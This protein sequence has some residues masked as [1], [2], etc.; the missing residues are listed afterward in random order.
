MQPTRL[1]EAAQA[2]AQPPLDEYFN[3]LFTALGPQHWWPGKTQ[4]EVIVGAILTQN[5]SWQNV[6]LALANLRGAGVFTPTAAAKVHIRS[7]QAL[8]RPSGY[9]RQ[10]ARALKAFVQFLQAQHRGS[11]KRMFATPTIELREKLLPSGE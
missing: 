8:I 7:L 4:F 11:L 2:E 6:E 9:F 1:P 5:T 10:K 3:S